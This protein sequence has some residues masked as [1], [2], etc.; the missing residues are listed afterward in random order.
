MKKIKRIELFEPG[1]EISPAK[2]YYDDKLSLI[3]WA[4]IIIV[5]VRA[6]V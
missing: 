3:T 6:L 2:K 5:I 1:E 4:F